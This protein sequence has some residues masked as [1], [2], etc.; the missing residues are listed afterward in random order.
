MKPSR[1]VRVRL[2]R[3][4]L[5]GLVIDMNNFFKGREILDVKVSFE[6]DCGQALILY[7]HEEDKEE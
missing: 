6:L 7:K 4:G 1:N 5:T 3:G 2:L